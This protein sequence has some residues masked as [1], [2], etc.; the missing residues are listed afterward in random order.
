M[1]LMF[2]GKCKPSASS[3]QSGHRARG[4]G[5][6]ILGLCVEGWW[7]YGEVGGTASVLE[8]RPA[9]ETALGGWRLGTARSGMREEGC[10][11]RRV[12]C[13]QGLA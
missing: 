12:F 5:G 8:S 2:D 6:D 1:G 4:A 11:V 9:A 13:A 10:S 7:G 3:P